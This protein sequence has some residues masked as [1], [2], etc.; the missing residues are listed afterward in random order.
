MSSSW[1]PIEKS[2][3]GQQ[4]RE[5]LTAV[6]PH[7]LI[8]YSTIPAPK[9]WGD[10]RGGRQKD[11]KSQMMRMS[12]VRLGLLPMMGNTLESTTNGYLSKTQ[13][14]I[15]PEAILIWMWKYYKTPPKLIAT[16]RGRTGLLSYRLSC[17]KWSVLNTN[18]EH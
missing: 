1:G 7:Q 8:H 6:V 3:N 11:C 16:E 10:C 5:Q 13:M 15:T 2:T 12:P 18:G 14:M 17:P 9:T 4:Y